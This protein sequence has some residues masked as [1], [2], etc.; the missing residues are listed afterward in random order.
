MA[1]HYNWFILIEPESGE[2][3]MD[4]DE[5]VAFQK[6]REKHPQGKFFFDRLNETGVFGRI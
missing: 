3:F 5:L 6:A 2:Y 4:E 1:E